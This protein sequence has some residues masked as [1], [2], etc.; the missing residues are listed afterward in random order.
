MNRRTTTGLILIVLFAGALAAIL[1]SRGVS[2]IVQNKGPQAIH[3]VTVHVTGNSYDIGTLMPGQT[4]KVRVTAKGDSHVEITFTDPSQHEHRVVADCY[5]EARN[6]KGTIS[7][8]IT[9]NQVSRV[10]EALE[11]SLF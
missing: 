9:G 8:D 1:P 4:Q 10:D 3:D 2:V 5:F 6:Y 7:V 11:L